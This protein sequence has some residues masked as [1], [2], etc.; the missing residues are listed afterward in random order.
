MTKYE[1]YKTT[2]AAGFFKSSSVTILQNA[3][4]RMPRELQWSGNMADNWKFCNKK[5]EFI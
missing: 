2:A 4:V 5:F 1:E 3:S